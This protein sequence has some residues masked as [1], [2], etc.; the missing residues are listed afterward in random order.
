[1]IH[2]VVTWRLKDN[3]GGNAKEAN[4]RLIRDKLLGLRGRIPGLVRLEVGLDF[5]A[6]P[7]SADVALVTEFESRDALAA[8]QAHP[9]HRAVAAFVAEAAAERRLVDFETA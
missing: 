2:H 8:Y 9:E 4:A 3:A 6:T 1:M 7:N 5:S